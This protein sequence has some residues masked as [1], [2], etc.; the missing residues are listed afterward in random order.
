MSLSEPIT[1]HRDA[2]KASRFSLL[3][4]SPYPSRMVYSPGNPL[5][6]TKGSA[7]TSADLA[8]C[9]ARVEDIDTVTFFGVE[10]NN[11]PVPNVSPAILHTKATYPLQPHSL[12]SQALT[13]EERL[14]FNYLEAAMLPGDRQTSSI[15]DFTVHVLHM[16]GYNDHIQSKLYPECEGKSCRRVICREHDI[17]L[18]SCGRTIH[19][20]ADACLLIPSNDHEGR[21]GDTVLLIVKAAPFTS[22]DSESSAEAQLFAQAIGAFQNLNRDR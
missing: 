11:F 10:T 7:W 20:T 15:I 9:N 19:T 5:K 2:F 21:N 22:P 13:Q 8:L 6:F 4:G 1:V 14:F 17:P 3:P 16:L 18:F 12:N